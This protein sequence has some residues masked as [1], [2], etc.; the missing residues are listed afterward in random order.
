MLKTY[1][2]IIL[3]LTGA[4]FFMIIAFSSSVARLVTAPIGSKFEKI[5]VKVSPM[6]KENIEGKVFCVLGNRLLDEKNRSEIENTLTNNNLLVVDIKNAQQIY[7]EQLLNKNISKTKIDYYIF[8]EDG[9]DGIFYY[10]LIDARN[11]KVA[12]ACKINSLSIENLMIPFKGF[13]HSIDLSFTQYYNTKKDKEYNE[14]LNSNRNEEFLK[15]TL[16]LVGE[17]KEKTFPNG[18]KQKKEDEFYNDFYAV[19]LNWATLSLLSRDFT[20]CKE[21]IELVRNVGKKTGYSLE[22][23]DDYIEKINSVMVKWSAAIKDSLNSVNINKENVQKKSINIS[24]DSDLSRDADKK[25]MYSHVV[26]VLFL[27]SSNVIDIYER[28]LMDEILSANTSVTEKAKG[29]TTGA[30]YLLSLAKNG[31]TNR[32]S[33]SVKTV[34]STSLTGE[35]KISSVIEYNY[36]IEANVTVKITRNSDAIAIGTTNLKFERKDK[37]PV[38]EVYSRATLFEKLFDDGNLN[39][40]LLNKIK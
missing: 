18:T 21:A 33:E 15:R 32:I 13:E 8:V 34:K 14:I 1:Q 27:T 25:L 24:N 20:K 6:I 37:S 23:Q 26:T 30:D 19:C 7:Q 4:I 2:K 12:Y 31:W 40:F 16:D 9:G 3:S 35:E 17:G 36:E 5:K 11:F 29:N 28:D 22:K 39:N 10:Q 38:K